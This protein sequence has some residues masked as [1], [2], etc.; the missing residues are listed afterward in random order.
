MPSFAT[1]GS[2][3]S[4][5]KSGE[6]FDVRTSPSRVGLIT[7]VFRRRPDVI[8]S[9]HPTNSVA[10]WGKKARPYVEGHE[11]SPTPYGHDTPYGRLAADERGHVLMMETHIHSFLHHLQERVDFPNLFLPEPAHAA[12]VDA[13]GSRRVITTRVMRP[14]TPYFVAVPSSKGHDPDWAVLHD[15]ALIFPPG[16][17][18]MLVENGYRFEGYP[19]IWRR[20]RD[21]HKKSAFRVASVRNSAVGL[22]NVKRFLN[23]IEGEF[24]E[25]IHRYR[26]YYDPDRIQE[27]GLPYV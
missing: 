3:A 2:M 13:S 27:L 22:L 17:D 24:T 26:R 15:F 25:L 12:V 8:R 18:R 11:D 20:R 21:L 5:V 6:V 1:G 4:Y 16:R 7:E 14:R 19:A 23:I 9:V 10:A